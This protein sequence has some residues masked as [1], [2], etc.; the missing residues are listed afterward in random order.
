MKPILRDL[1]MELE[2]ERL[3]IRAPRPGDGVVLNAAKRAS[4]DDLKPWMVWAQEIGSVDD[5][6]EWARRMHASY[7]T[8]D[9]LTM[10]AFLKGTSEFVLGTGLHRIDWDVPKFEIGY[11]VNSPYAGNGYVTEAVA[12][13][14]EFAFE[15]GARRVIIECDEHNEKSAAVARRLDYPL[16]GVRRNDTRGTDGELRNTLQFA[17]TSDAN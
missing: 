15:L 13:V 10:V 1:P 17:K 16:E 7:L 14:E 11:W 12:R 2:T 4:H 9:E 3:T 6:E 8:R 5:D